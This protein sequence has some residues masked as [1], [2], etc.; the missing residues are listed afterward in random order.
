[1]VEAEKRY[2]TAKKCEVVEGGRDVP[3]LGVRA[4]QLNVNTN[5]A[6]CT[7]QIPAITVST[8]PLPDSPDKPAL[9]HLH[10]PTMTRITHF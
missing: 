3:P 1:M 6:W 8:A 5:Q 10:A 2:R 7:S 9:Q 4:N